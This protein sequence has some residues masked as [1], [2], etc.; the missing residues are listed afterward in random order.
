RQVA[1]RSTSLNSGGVRLERFVEIRSLINEE[2]EAVWNGQKPADLALREAAARG[3]VL[4]L[5]KAQ[6]T[7]VEPD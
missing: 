7:P 2:L 5:E 4:L 3:T 6:E 1:N